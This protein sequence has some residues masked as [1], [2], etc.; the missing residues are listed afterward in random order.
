VPARVVVLASGSGTLLQALIDAAS[1]GHLSADI[2]AVGSDVSDCGA[3]ER[4]RRAGIAAFVVPPAEH[5]DRAA[6]NLALRDALAAERPD[7]VVSAGFM[8][9]MGAPVVDAFRIVNTHPS[10][11]PAFPG[12]HAVRDALAAGVPVTGCTVHWVDH[13]VDTG[14]VIAQETV[15][16][17]T[18]DDEESLHERIKEVERRLIVRVVADLTGGANG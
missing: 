8:R 2:V 12:A 6:W 9:I 16:V 1:T 4:A 13:G 15:A 3:V 5:P 18:G 17:L 7:L 14:P 11:L 10:L